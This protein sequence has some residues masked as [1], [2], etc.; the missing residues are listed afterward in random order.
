MCVFCFVIDRV[1]TNAFLFFI[2]VWHV[3]IYCPIAHI[4]WFPTGWFRENIVEDFAGGVVVNM[5]AAV[6]MISLHIC[7]GVYDK[8]VTYPTTR[9]QTSLQYGLVVFFLWFGWTVG[10]AGNSGPVAGQALA[11]CIVAAMAGIMT[12]Y[13]Y[14]L[15]FD[16]NF[17]S[18]ATAN[19]IM[20]SLVAVLPAAGFVTV[21]G[22]MLIAIITTMVT[23]YAARCWFNELNHPNESMSAVVVHGLGG[24]VGFI[25]TAVFSYEYINPEFPAKKGL[26]SGRGMN[27]ARHLAAMCGVWVCCFVGTMIITFVCNLLVPLASDAEID[28]HAA[29]GEEDFDGDEQEGNPDYGMEM[30]QADKQV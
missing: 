3:C 23:I 2:A 25:L 10:K 4:A 26:T 22:A 19:S 27:L 13:L 17:N 12:W 29:G 8:P 16:R 15:Y 9:P 14:A 6:S 20:L 7:L 24:T 11:N 21:G 5:L 1:N 18:V 28:R 30:Q